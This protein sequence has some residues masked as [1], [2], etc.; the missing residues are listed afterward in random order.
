M[1]APFWAPPPE[2]YPGRLP[3]KA[4]V[5][6]VGGGIAGVS[7]LHHLA[8]RRIHA[9][10]LERGRLASGATGRSAGFLLAGVASSYAEAV[11][12]HGRERAREVW[13]LTN[14]NHDRMIEAVRG[15]DV[16]YRRLGSAI[17]PASEEER[18]LLVESEQL[19]REDGFEARWDGRSLVNPRD[20][21]VDPAALVAA[22]ARQARPG[23][24]REGVD[25]RTVEP[26]RH[27]VIVTAGDMECEAGVVI[28][29][30]NAYT[31]PLAPGLDIQPTRAQMAATA[32]DARLVAERP[33][34]SNFGYRYWRQLASGEVLIG[35]WRDT[36]PET[37]QTADAEPAPHVQEKLDSALRELG[38]TAAV[39]HRWA[40][41][42]GF[43][44][45]GLPFAGPVEGMPNVY[46]CA[47][48]TGHG[49]GFAFI[50]AMRVA[51]TI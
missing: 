30:T 24:I 32:A 7:L 14:E 20:G 31:G 19:L 11:R 22:I 42:M 13:A 1:T 36:S 26:R 27:G 47:G 35:G 51:E 28:L 23:R 15:Q 29:A 40:G 45:S 34:Y 4:D 49:L 39:T 9:V 3:D 41:I 5:L 25:V 43:T 37:E 6:I 17:V 12:T 44:K 18:A 16:S 33:V 50:S 21:E 38:V 46:A 10:L 2:T 48:F 8:R